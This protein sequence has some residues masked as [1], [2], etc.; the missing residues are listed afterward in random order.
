M[1]KLVSKP[2]NNVEDKDKELGEA[3]VKAPSAGG[4]KPLIP[5]GPTTPGMSRQ[6]LIPISHKDFNEFITGKGF[7]GNNNYKL[8]ELKA[9]FG[10]KPLTNKKQITVTID[11]GKKFSTY[12][13]ISK[14]SLASGIPYT[15]LLQARKKSK[16]SSKSDN[17]VPTM[18]GGNLYVIKF[19]AI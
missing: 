4:A 13:S 11:D 9:M 17:P 14:A 1:E 10:F 12:E 8:K 19:N 18:S 6:G 16:L 3:G 7:V 15:T 5:M 2:E